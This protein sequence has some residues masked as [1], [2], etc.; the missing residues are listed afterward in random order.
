MSENVTPTTPT[1]TTTVTSYD[2]I[3]IGSQAFPDVQ[4]GTLT[5]ERGRKRKKHECLDGSSVIE[6][7][8]MKSASGTVSYDGLLETDVQKIK[9]A[10]DDVVV[11]MT[12]YD[13][14]SGAS[15]T[16]YAEISNVQVEKIIHDGVGNG[17]SAWSLSFDFEKVGDVSGASS[18]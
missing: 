3:A 15:S 4:K 17:L 1:T 18:I 10:C 12:I 14:I 6:V 5:F 8:S 11:T 7:Y 16:F 2:L 9:D 13:P